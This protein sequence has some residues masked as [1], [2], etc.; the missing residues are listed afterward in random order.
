MRFLVS[1]IL[2]YAAL[3]QSNDYAWRQ[4]HPRIRSDSK[5]P[6][7]YEFHPTS[8]KG[9]SAVNIAGKVYVFGGFAKLPNCMTTGN[10][11]QENCSEPSFEYSNELWKFDPV[12]STWE[13]LIPKNGIQPEGREQHSA[14]VLSDNRMLVFGGR[15]RL[16]DPGNGTSR[17]A[18]LSDVWLLDVGRI[19]KHTFRHS[20]E[21]VE[22]PEGKFLRKNLIINVEKSEDVGTEDLCV[23]DVKVRV[24][25]SHPCTRQLSLSLYGPQGNQVEV[26]ATIIV[27]F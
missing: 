9:S 20:E 5:F 25:I 17:Y 24:S 14:T 4:I 12:D 15:S 3:V 21:R 2:C 19:T 23:D 7:K 6:Q 22:I 8:R 26:S 27:S 13:L 10:I 1:V 18:Y 11:E 16:K